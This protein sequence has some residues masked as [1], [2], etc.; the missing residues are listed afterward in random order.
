[1]FTL[2]SPPLWPSCAHWEPFPTLLHLGTGN[3]LDLGLVGFR[4]LNEG[5]DCTNSYDLKLPGVAAVSWELN[6]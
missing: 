5:P 3:C 2:A 4:L 6:R 1:M